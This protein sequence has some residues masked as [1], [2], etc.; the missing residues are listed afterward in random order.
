MPVSTL[1]GL[2]PR[3]TRMNLKGRRVGSRDGGR[4][5]SWE[6]FRRSQEFLIRLDLAT[7]RA[8]FTTISGVCDT[9]SIG[10]KGIRLAQGQ[11]K[12]GSSSSSPGSQDLE[13]DGPGE[14]PKG[15]LSSVALLW[16]VPL[17]N[18]GLLQQ[19]IADFREMHP[20]NTWSFSKR[21]SRSSNWASFL[22]VKQFSYMG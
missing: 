11:W 18:Y 19:E 15:C 17:M 4:T 5:C 3:S 2:L 20:I 21:A 13:C 9:R 1:L 8:T 6:K 14:V 7:N 10:S 12:V 22:P 16:K